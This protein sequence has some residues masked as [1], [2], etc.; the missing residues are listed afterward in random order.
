MKKFETYTALVF[1]VGLIATFTVP[2]FYDMYRD[3]IQKMI[4][5]VSHMY[6]DAK[7]R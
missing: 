2:K 6:E 4:E 1:Y 3:E 5:K 7:A